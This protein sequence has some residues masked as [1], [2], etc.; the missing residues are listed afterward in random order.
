M[1][2]YMNISIFENLNIQIFKC[3]TKIAGSLSLCKQMLIIL[4]P[5][6]LGIKKEKLSRKFSKIE[7]VKNQDS[8]LILLI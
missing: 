1:F 2:E 8:L 6:W 5:V 4:F 7:K 3:L